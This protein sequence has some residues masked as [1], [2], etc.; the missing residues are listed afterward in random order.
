MTA[1]GKLFLD[2]L[3]KLKDEHN[4]SYHRSTRNKPTDANHFSWTE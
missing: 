3:N 1:N 2:S 4:N